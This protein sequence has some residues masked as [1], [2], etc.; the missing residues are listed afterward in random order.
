[1][2]GQRALLGRERVALLGQLAVGLD[3]RLLRLAQRAAGV[4][5]LFT[6]LVVFEAGQHFLDQVALF[7]GQVFVL[8]IIGHAQ[9]QAFEVDARGFEFGLEALQL[10]LGVAL[11]ALGFVVGV[12]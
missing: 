2:L 9:A 7:L 4:A 12:Q 3:Q 11:V 1:G 10:G 8:V 6:R 5:R